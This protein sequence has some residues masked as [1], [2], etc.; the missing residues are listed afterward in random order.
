M[1]ALWVTLCVWQPV[2][3]YRLVALGVYEQTVYEKA[4]LKKQLAR[5]VLDD[6]DANA[7]VNQL[8]EPPQ[9]QLG[10]ENR[11]SARCQRDVPTAT[12]VRDLQQ[13][14]AA[15]D[16]PW[17]CRISE[18]QEQVQQ[19]SPSG[20]FKEPHTLLELSEQERQTALG[21]LQWHQVYGS[22]RTPSSRRTPQPRTGSGKPFARIG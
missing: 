15:R 18:H 19:T 2:F 20:D 14:G 1:C 16:Q 8:L 9:E 11:L 22:A 21:E 10:V 17:L 6:I 7:L 4:L 5:W 3:I 13:P 12:I